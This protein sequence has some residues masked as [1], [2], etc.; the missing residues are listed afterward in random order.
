M[1]LAASALTAP[2]LTAAVPPANAVGLLADSP[3]SRAVSVVLAW[4]LVTLTVAAVLVVIAPQYTRGV[5]DDVIDRP[6]T[7]FAIGFVTVFGLFVGSALL[8]FVAT[9][10]EHSTLALLGLI[11]GAPGLITVAVLLVGGGCVGAIVVGDRLGSRIGS[12]SPSLWRSL[13]IGTLLLGAS[14]LVPILGTIVTIAVATGGSGAIVSAWYEGQWGTPL[15][16]AATDDAVDQESVPGSSTRPGR[17]GSEP[18]PSSEPPE[19][20]PTLGAAPTAS[21]HAGATVENDRTDDLKGRVG[22]ESSSGDDSQ[23]SEAYGWGSESADQTTDNN[24]WSDAADEQ[25]S[26]DD[27][28]SSDSDAGTVDDFGW[29]SDSDGRTDDDYGW[30]DDG[31][32]WSDDGAR[33]DDDRRDDTD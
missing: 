28:W 29:N 1:V 17:D 21:G 3:L 11:V 23:S 19:S 24:G 7:A 26:D 16:A 10:L 22:D 2:S 15:L 8:P 6:D 5:R 18:N 4:V 13:G 9:S 30:S 12:G 27:G 14:Q 20:D 32:G 31:Y 33:D 25:A